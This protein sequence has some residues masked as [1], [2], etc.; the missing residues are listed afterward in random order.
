LSRARRTGEL[1]IG[2]SDDQTILGIQHD[3]FA[4]N[5]KFLLH[6]RNLITDKLIPNV[7]QYVEYAVVPC[8]DKQ[9]CQITCK[10]SKDDIWLKPDKNTPEMFYVRSGPSSAELPPREA[11]RYIREHF[12]K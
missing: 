10:P 12:Q 4:N 5:D 9:I 1:L 7:V 11:I 8:D 2:V 6:L 3:H